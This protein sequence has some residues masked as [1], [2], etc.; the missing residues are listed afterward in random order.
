MRLQ[1]GKEVPDSI[2]QKIEP[3]IHSTNVGSNACLVAFDVTRSLRDRGKKK[4]EDRTAI[5]YTKMDASLP[6]D[7]IA[8]MATLAD[9]YAVQA[10]TST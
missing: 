9:T 4:G 2:P 6:F 10:L 5:S 8:R 3:V 7:E 1:A